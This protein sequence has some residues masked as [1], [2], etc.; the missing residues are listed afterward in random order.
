MIEAQPAA[1]RAVAELDVGPFADSLRGAR[2]IHVVGT[3]TSFHA[4][5]LGAQLLQRGGVPRGRGAVGGL[6]RGGAGADRR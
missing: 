2:R 1:L 6:R 5:E 3:G 4:A